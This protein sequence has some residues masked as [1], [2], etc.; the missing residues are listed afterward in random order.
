MQL[1]INIPDNKVDFFLDELRQHF[2][3]AEVEIPDKYAVADT[4]SK[5]ENPSPSG[6]PWF[7]DPKNLAIVDEGMRQYKAGLAKPLE[8]CPEVQAFLAK[9]R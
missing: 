3:F 6:D 1:T 9:Y 2:A 4:V 5:P 8:E 7:D